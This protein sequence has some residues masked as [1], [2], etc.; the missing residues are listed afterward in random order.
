LVGEAPDSRRSAKEWRIHSGSRFPDLDRKSVARV[1][2]VA[3]VRIIVTDAGELAAGMSVGDGEGSA[4]VRPIDL[5]AAQKVPVPKG[6]PLEHSALAAYVET[7]VQKLLKERK[8]VWFV[9]LDS[10]QRFSQFSVMPEI[11]NEAG[12]VH[13]L[14]YIEEGGKTRPRYVTVLRVR[15]LWPNGDEAWVV[16]EVENG[17]YSDGS[18]PMVFGI[19]HGE[20]IDPKWV[21]MHIVGSIG[22][23]LGNRAMTLSLPGLR[24]TE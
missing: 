12:D 11:L 16:P 22:Q 5:V 18:V 20:I 6:H 14:S 24:S 23:L 1:D 3:P 21:A 9:P 13:P 2:P 7:V 4:G 15:N 8:S 17:E 19:D 10:R